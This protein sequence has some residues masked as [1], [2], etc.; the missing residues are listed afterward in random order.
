MNIISLR[1][2]RIAGFTV[3][4]VTASPFVQMEAADSLPMHLSFDLYRR[5]CPCRF[6]A[7]KQGTTCHQAGWFAVVPEC[8]RCLESLLN[9]RM[10]VN[11]QQKPVSLFPSVA[12]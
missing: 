1:T 11:L 10:T 2:F 8:L 12:G 4:S 9:L 6:P 5:S 7:E 3:N